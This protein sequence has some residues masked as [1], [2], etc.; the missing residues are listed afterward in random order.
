MR[1]NKIIYLGLILV[2]GLAAGAFAEEAKNEPKEIVATKTIT[3]EVSGISSNFIAIMYGVDKKN[4]ASLEMALAV[5]KDV[6][7]E[8]KDTLKNIGVGDT[9]KAVYEEKTEKD[10]KEN[11][12]VK[13]RIVKKITFLQAAKKTE[14]TDTLISQ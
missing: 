4:E 5:G 11:I 1:R 2:L 14:Q 13:S 10:E 8:H 6:V 3:G 12:R 7:I 9:V